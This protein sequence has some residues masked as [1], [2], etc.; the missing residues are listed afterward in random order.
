MHNPGT[1]PR[2]IRV[3]YGSTEAEVLLS[4][5]GEHAIQPAPDTA[6]TA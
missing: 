6:G 3:R 5:G 1:E 2:A 4:A